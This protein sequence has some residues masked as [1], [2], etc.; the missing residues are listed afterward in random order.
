MLM[1]KIIVLLSIVFFAI[2]VWAFAAETA[3][4]EL[5]PT[6]KL[7]QA[8]VAFLTAIKKDLGAGNFKAVVKNADELAAETKKTGEKLTNPL[9]KDITLAVS[10]LAKDASAAAAKGDAA[11]VKTKL[12]GIKGKCDECHAKIRDKK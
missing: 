12:G 1:K 7:M 8:R 9:A 2:A 11:T 3:K 6:Q 5:R 10:M 4:T